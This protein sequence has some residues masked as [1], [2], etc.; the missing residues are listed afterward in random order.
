MRCS[1]RSWKKR[2]RCRKLPGT[3]VLS[4]SMRVLLGF[5]TGANVRFWLPSAQMI[6]PQPDPLKAQQALCELVRAVMCR[7]D[8]TS[9]TQRLAQTSYGDPSKPAVR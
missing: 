2:W 5:T 8:S 9:G 4:S 3:C 6:S 1:L 7:A